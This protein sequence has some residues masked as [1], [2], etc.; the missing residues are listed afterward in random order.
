MLAS[1]T[2]GGGEKTT[3]GVEKREKEK[4]EQLIRVKRRDRQKKKT[5]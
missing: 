1:K 4:R 2:R 3:Q 5:K